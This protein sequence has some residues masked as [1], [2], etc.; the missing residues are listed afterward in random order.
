MW[1]IIILAWKFAVWTEDDICLTFFPL[2]PLFFMPAKPRSIL[3]ALTGIQY[4]SPILEAAM[5]HKWLW[6]R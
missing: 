2:Y 3:G 1:V 6:F 4:L 5:G